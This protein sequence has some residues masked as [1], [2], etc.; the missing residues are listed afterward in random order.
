MRTT[1]RERSVALVSACVV[2]L[3][4]NAPSPAAV[5]A[6]KAA[7]PGHAA[8][9]QAHPDFAGYWSFDGWIAKNLEPLD[10]RVLRTME[11]EAL[12]LQPWAKK[13]YEERIDLQRHDDAFS[14]TNTYCLPSGVP[15]ILTGSNYPMEILQ[16]PHQLLMVFEVM[17]E[18]R[19][20]YIDRAHDSEVYPS[21]EGDSVARWDGDVLVVDTVGLTDR[22]TIDKMGLPHTTALRVG[23]R[24]RLLGPD[25]LEEVVTIDDPK[26]FTRPFKLRYTYSRMPADT[27]IGEY[28]CNENQRNAPNA[29]GK[30]AI[31]LPK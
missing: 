22:T 27:K 24:I 6:P 28:V 12:P 1:I 23:E 7:R 13:I 14:D 25:K 30:S 15:H 17:N 3:C 18:F 9:G 4:A 26:T 8:A 21:W 5:A 19:Y 29:E 20:I 16:T 31:Q 10:K 11:G 2:A